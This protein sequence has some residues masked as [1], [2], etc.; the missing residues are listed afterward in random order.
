M[1]VP[2]IPKPEFERLSPNFEFVNQR[3]AKSPWQ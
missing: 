1:Q 3:L 2:F